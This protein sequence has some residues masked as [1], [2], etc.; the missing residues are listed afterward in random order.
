MLPDEI[1][2]HFAAYGGDAGDEAFPQVAF[3]MKFLGI[4]HAT[5]GHHSPF[6]GSEAGFGRKVFSRIGFRSAGLPCIVQGSRTPGHGVG[7]LQMRPGVRQGVLDRL[8]LADRPVEYDTLV[9]IRHCL[10]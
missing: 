8:V 1:E 3:H 9:G 2:N 4:A 6:T 5:M 10:P 7:C